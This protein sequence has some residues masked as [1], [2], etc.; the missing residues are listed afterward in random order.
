[1]TFPSAIGDNF[2]LQLTPVVDAITFSRHQCVSPGLDFFY[3]KRAGK[4][5]IINSYW[6]IWLWVR[7]WYTNVICT[8]RTGVCALY[9]EVGFSTQETEEF[10]VWRYAEYHITYFYLPAL[11]NGL[12]VCSNFPLSSIGNPLEITGTKEGPALSLPFLEDYPRKVSMAPQ[13]PSS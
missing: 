2:W 11:Q 6:G 1:M 12:I 10:D 13:F 4:V 5:L 3:W 8:Y 9:Y 7:G